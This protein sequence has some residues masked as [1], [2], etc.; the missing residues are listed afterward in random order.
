MSTSFAKVLGV[1]SLCTALFT[2]GC[3]GGGSKT[4]VRFLNAV[5]DQS[6]VNVLLDGTVV[7]TSLGYASPGSYMVT[8]SGSRHLQVE[9]STGSTIFLD[10]M[11]NL[12][13]G[14]NTTV[15]LANRSTN[16]SAIVLAD[17]NTAPATGNIKLR[18]VNASPSLG[19]GPVDVYIV[20]P[21]T[22][23]NTVS[24]TVTSLGFG[25]A[26]DY[27]SLTAG[28]YE[29]FFTPHQSTFA[30][31]DTGALSFSSGQN[32]TVAVVDSLSAGFQIVTLADLN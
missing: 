24:P 29:I 25:S 10:Q 20:T 11:L 31:L 27:Q 6:S 28:S 22:N 15:I 13:N 17:N 9:P 16:S 26:S 30:F 8:K 4:N 5:P 19:G 7:S 3:G 21:G 1:F 23:L 14:V 18:I 12:G 32:R 2:V